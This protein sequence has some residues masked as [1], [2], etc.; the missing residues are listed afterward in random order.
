MISGNSEAI[1]ND[2]PEQIF[3]CK[4]SRAH[5]APRLFGL[6]V[7]VRREDAGLVRRVAVAL[8]DPARQSEARLL[9]GNALPNRAR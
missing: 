9:F 2:Q 1:E 3:S 8:S 5:G 7:N 4:S 6:E